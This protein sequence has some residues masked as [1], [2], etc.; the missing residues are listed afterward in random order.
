MIN[1]HKY[2]LVKFDQTYPYGDTH[3][4]F[5]KVAADCISKAGLMIGEVQIQ[6]KEG[7]HY[8]A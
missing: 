6:G 7:T 3:D 8:A 1:V 2:V 5:K 4:I